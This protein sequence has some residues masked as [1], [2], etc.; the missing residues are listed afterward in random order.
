MNSDNNLEPSSITDKPIMAR[1][2]ADHPQLAQLP[3]WPTRTIAVLS[4]L[5]GGPHA[6]RVAA[7][8]RAGE[9]RILVSLERSRRSLARLRANPHVAL[10]IFTAGNCAFTA[11]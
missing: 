10:A 8:V 4:T 9:Q 2:P 1:G 6:I 11:L 5:D 7:P 3:E